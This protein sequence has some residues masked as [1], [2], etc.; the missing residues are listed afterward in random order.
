VAS[1]EQSEAGL[2]RLAPG[3]ARQDLA[4]V[5]LACLCGFGRTHGA[6][7]FKEWGWP[8]PTPDVLERLATS[9]PG[10]DPRLATR[11][12]E[13]AR[14]SA[15][16]AIA[17]AARAGLALVTPENLA[18]PPL[19]REIPDPPVV[20]WVRGDPASLSRP[21][22]AIVGARAAT[23]AGLEVA[24]RLGRDLAHAGLTVVSGLARGVD[25]AGHRGA[26][27]G[28]GY[29]VGVLGCG[30]DLVYPPEHS[31][32]TE[33][34]VGSGGAVVSEFPPGMAPLT[35]HFPL[36]NR[37]ISG[38]VRAVVVVEA[39]PKSG[40]LITA[41]AAL[42]QGRDVLAVPGNV[43]SGRY[44]G[45]HALIKDGAR[46][47]ETVGDV[48][49][50]LKWYHPAL[51]P[52]PSADNSLEMSELEKVMAAG[53]PYSLE[54]LSARTGQPIAAILAELT[55]LELDG[56]V[57]RLPGGV[58]ARLDG[59]VMDIRGTAKPAT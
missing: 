4:H 50:E 53:E 45:S 37:I 22:V 33:E 18:F 40:S 6:R 47:V 29:T 58:F 23:P 2:D 15:R 35:H 36:R 26:L 20:L 57:S 19:L 54:D 17:S 7:L 42:E 48:L 31:E 59:S 39:S 51:S 11:E 12:I 16:A 5:T 44:G 14:E 3:P 32:L 28:G 55:R 43:A 38:L 41:R 30:A 21:A 52:S 46:L 9:L 25:G 49:E 56:R 10:R 8:A 13:R 1:R 34:I 24:R 27:D